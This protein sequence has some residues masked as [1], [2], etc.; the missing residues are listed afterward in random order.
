MTR[1]EVEAA[2]AA[3]VDTESTVG[4][5]W[6]SGAEM[7][8]IVFRRWSSFE[9]RNRIK[10]PTAED[11]SLDLAKGLQAHFEPV[12]PYTPLSEWLHLARILAEVLGRDGERGA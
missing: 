7:A 6:W 10:H 1:C 11:R 4:L 12:I 2:L 3:A 5:R 9:R 8:P